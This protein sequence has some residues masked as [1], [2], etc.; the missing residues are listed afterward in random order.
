[1]DNHYG[2]QCPEPGTVVEVASLEPVERLI[3][4][5]ME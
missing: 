5:L 2:E 1:M 3:K 4:V